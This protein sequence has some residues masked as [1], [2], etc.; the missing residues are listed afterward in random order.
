MGDIIWKDYAP[1]FRI[2][3]RHILLSGGGEERPRDRVVFEGGKVRIVHFGYVGHQC[4][5]YNEAHEG[6]SGSRWGYSVASQ[7]GVNMSNDSVDSLRYNPNRNLSTYNVPGTE[8]RQCE[9]S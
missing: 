7:L 9:C 3:I 4:G 5:K 6:D 2:W 1:E 8:I